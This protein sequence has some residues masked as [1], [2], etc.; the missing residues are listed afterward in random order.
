[1]IQSLKKAF[2]YTLPILTGY[3][4]L[5]LA[6]GLLMNRTGLSF[7]WVMAMS[8]LVFAGALQFAAIPLLTGLFNP[9]AAF[10]LAL[11]VNIRH[12][13]Y[14]ISMLSKYRNMG[15][16]KFFTI[17]MMADEAFSIQAAVDLK[18]EDNPQLFY[19]F[20]AL[21]CYLYWNSFSLMGYFLGQYV[22]SSIV[23]FD[24]VLT[25]LF[26]ILFL[27]QWEHP[28]HRPYLL[29]GVGAT[30]ISLFVLGKSNFLL[31]SMVLILLLIFMVKEK[32]HD[33]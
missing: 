27:N 31:G 5:G 3:A 33:E 2:P 22:P 20:T 6:Y 23:G 16:K 30:L 29:I 26:Y 24:F 13:F 7:T 10:T 32:K 18:E 1:M 19:F 15:I 9:L 21:I 11:L 8:G 25:A 17:Y 28:E 4:F 14:G 12:V